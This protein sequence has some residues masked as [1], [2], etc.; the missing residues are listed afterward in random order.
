MARKFQQTKL[1]KPKKPLEA[2]FQIDAALFEELGERLVSRPEIA[3]AELVKNAYD[4]DSPQCNIAISEHEIVVSDAGHGLTEK[5]FLG[6]WMVVSTQDKGRKRFSRLYGRSMAGSKGVGRFSARFLGNWLELISIAEDPADGKKY[7]LQAIFDWKDIAQKR[8]IQSIVIPYQIDSVPANTQTG[9]TLKITDLRDHVRDLAK[10]RVKTDVL[11][12]ID[13]A[14]GLESPSFYE[15]V[16]KSRTSKADPGFAVTFKE[17]DSSDEG[18]G[19]RLP[20][21]QEDV[22]KAILDAYV[23][24]VR[25]H[26]DEAGMVDL[27]VFWR[28]QPKPIEKK[29]FS[30]SKHATPFTYK[31]FSEHQ[32]ET[33]HRG[34]PTPLQDI[35]HLPLAA[36]LNSP[37]FIDLRFFPKRKGTFTNLDVNGRVAQSWLK[38]HGSFAIVD[39]KFVMPAYADQDSDWLAIDASKASNE[40]SWQSIFTPAFYPMDPSDKAD[41]QR[42]PMLALPRMSQLIGRIHISTQKRLDDENDDSWLQPNMDRESLRANGAFNLLWH[43][44]RFAA[45]AVAHFDRKLRLAEIEKQEKEAQQ[46]ARTALSS[47][48]EEIRGSKQIEPAYRAKV[49]QQLKAAEAR[50]KEAAAYEQD[51]RLSL[52]LMSLMGVMAGFMTHEFEKALGTL[53]KV[54]RDLRKFAKFSPELKQV[55]EDVLENESSLANYL[56][57]MRLFVN[58]AREPRPQDFKAKA[59]ISVATGTLVSLASAHDIDIVVDVDPKLPGPFVP[60]A[61]YHGIII[62]LVS[63]AMKALVP[64][65]GPAARKIRI[66][67]TNEGD[68]HVLVCADNGIGVPEYLRDRIWDPLFTTTADDENPLGSGLGLGLSVVQRV[69][70]KIGGRIELMETAPPGFVT[71]FRVALPT[72]GY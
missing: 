12:L 32:G 8:T 43:L 38:E 30:L 69:V 68:R 7:R 28:D 54:A 9:T 52:E 63:N 50:F 45:E 29:R 1:P 16:R 59:Q 33:D 6:N 22:A 27:R 15:D 10:D 71:A 49:V 66:Y 18:D 25:I 57:Y 56:E 46:A 61:A 62:N 23:A 64:K 11:R 40:R 58:K 44:S 60:L 14:G 4:A 48:I 24:R 19:D 35:Q 41:T 3:L 70:S 47:A 2:R 42:N 36:K 39:N 13:P 65:V 67:A 5:E 34:V 72:H 17:T 55:A 26:V 31:K 51:A 53:K 21:E 37:V 20:S